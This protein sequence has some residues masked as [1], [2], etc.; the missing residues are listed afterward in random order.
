MRHALILTILILIV[1]FAG[2]AAADDTGIPF[3]PAAQ[4]R[5]AH[6]PSASNDPDGFLRCVD[7]MELAALDRWHAMYV[8]QHP[9]AT[10]CRENPPLPSD[11]SLVSLCHTLIDQ[12]DTA[13]AHHKDK[14]R[15]N[16]S[17][18]R[19]KVIEYAAKKAARKIVR[20]NTPLGID[21]E[22]EIARLD[23]EIARMERGMER[24]LLSPVPMMREPIHCTSYSLG[25]SVNTDC[26]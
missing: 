6:L 24:M 20:L 19:T 23:A 17:L 1:S 11:L 2:L 16:M 14:L 8:V 3:P 18:L 22:E 7:I 26:Y 21:G 12:E 9:T 4:A 15:L 10:V 13:V 5:I 25:I